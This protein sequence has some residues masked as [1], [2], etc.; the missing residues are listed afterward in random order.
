[1]N[2]I[3]HGNGREIRMHHADKDQ[4]QHRITVPV[5]VFTKSKNK[6]EK[7]V[8]VERQ[9]AYRLVHQV[10]DLYHYRLEAHKEN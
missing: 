2:I 7:P 1:M 6:W 9:E 8:Y 10:G 5:R 4:V 3:L